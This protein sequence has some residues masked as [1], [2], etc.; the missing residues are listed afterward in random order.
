VVLVLDRDVLPGGT[1]PDLVIF[2]IVAIGTPVVVG[3]I[4]AEVVAVYLL[5]ASRFGINLN[6]AFAG[7]S[8]EDHKGF[9]RLHIDSTGTLTVYPIKLD[10]VCRRWR[11]DP[12]GAPSDPWLRPD[13]VE[14]KPELIEEP[15]SVPRRHDVTR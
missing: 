4:D 2:A 8:I 13:G 11:L 6:E 12:D 9:L 1:G 5:V 10:T 14:L 7:Q 3:F 15:F